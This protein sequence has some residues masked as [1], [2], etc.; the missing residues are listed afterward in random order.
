MN[1]VSPSYQIMT[2]I[3]R[4]VIL[5]SIEMAGRTCYKSEDKITPDSAA[6][7]VRHILSIGHES[8]IEHINI[9]VKFWCDRGVTH[10]LVRHRLAAYSQESTRYCNYAKRGEIVVINPCF[11][12]GESEQDH[13]NRVRWVKAMEFAQN[14]YLEMVQDGAS[15]QEARSVLP[16]ALK[17]EIVTTMNLREWRHVMRL[18]TSNKAH[19][20]MRELMLPLLDEFQQKLPE[21][22]EGINFKGTYVA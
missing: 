9:T 12:N 10:E 22:F 13:R 4:E 1:I 20:Q 3:D 18:R 8:V 11:W 14:T 16:N 21:I 7:F 15:P 5:Q 2:P 6:K 19:P 17:T